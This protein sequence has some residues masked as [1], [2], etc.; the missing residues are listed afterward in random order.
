MD[1]STNGGTI[2]FSANW[3]SN[4]AVSDDVDSLPGTF[5]LSGMQQEL[6][7][8]TTVQ[9][10]SVV[11]TPALIRVRQRN[12]DAA[13]AGTLELSDAEWA[14]DSLTLTIS[15]VDPLAISRQTGFV[16]SDFIG[17]S[18]ER[19]TNQDTGYLF[20]VGSN[21]AV[22][23]NPNPRFRPVYLTPV[24]PAENTFSVR[25]ANLSATNDRTDGG[26]GY[27]L[28][29][30][31][32]TLTDIN[33]NYYYA[34]D[35]P[36]GN[37]PTDIDLYYPV[38]DGKFSTVAQR[39]QDSI[40]Y[41]A[42]GL[43]ASNDT[44]PAHTAEFDRVASLKAHNDFSQPLFTQ[45]G[46]DTDDDGVP[47]RY[48]LDADNDGIANID[49]APADPYAD[50]NGNNI[51]DYIDPDH[52]G[53]GVFV[54]R[55]CSNYDFD[56]DGI[57]NH[58]DLDSDGDGILDIRE[59]GG[60]DPE[61][62]GMVEYAIAGVPSSMLDLDRDGF[63][64]ERD[65]LVGNRAPDG[66]P[67]VSDGT[68]WPQPDRDGDGLRNFLDIDS[69][70][71]G[72]PDFVEAQPTAL[73][74]VPDSVDANRNGIQAAHDIAENGFFGMVPV[75]TDGDGTPDYLDLNSDD[76]R[77]ADIAEAHDYDGDGFSDLPAPSGSDT[78]GDGLD[79]IFDLYVRGQAVTSN[80]TN[81]RFAQF[82]SNQ[83]APATDERDWRERGCKQQ[84]CLPLGTERNQRP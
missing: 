81:G 1:D 18:L 16:S 54:S 84:D 45:A 56:G 38:A 44:P 78:D 6:R 55:V 33:S 62:D 73:W 15:N 60:D 24:A 8:A 41:D 4:T 35:R 65:H 31:D 12:G 79:D 39:Q 70:G 9:F 71:D 68:P 76:E 82:Y 75:D 37:T 11:C 63:H 40:W 77:T 14:T 66:W 57:A 49:E 64:D 13:I 5:V 50:T 58:L 17:G 34:I 52:P 7:A 2:H 20:P 46:S 23:R 30:R 51:F 42:N 26:T 27:D 72:I 43:V 29:A 28:I 25:F 67:E 3:T 36:A 21:G 53:C 69:D 59:A 19:H 47:D 48:D 32:P 83:E 74:Y 10:P 22:H 61:L 80:A